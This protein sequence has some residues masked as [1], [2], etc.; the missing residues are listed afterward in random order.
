MRALSRLKVLVLLNQVA[1]AER[2]R[3]DAE[4]EH[5]EDAGLGA[6]EVAGE[7]D[8]TLAEVAAG[9]FIGV[10]VENAALGATG[11]DQNGKAGVEGALDGR[12]GL[13]G[14]VAASGAFN[15]EAASAE[16]AGGIDEAAIG[17][18]VHLVQVHAIFKAA[19]V[20]GLAEAE[21]AGKEDAVFVDDAE[22]AEDGGLEGFNGLGV[23]LGGVGSGVDGFVEED[24]DALIA[25]G[26][27]DGNAEG[28]ADVGR[29][30]IRE[31]RGVTHGTDDDDW[32]G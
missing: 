25:G 23:G 3:G 13:R 26:R 21:G 18:G 11:R 32:L 24:K 12:Q 14:N 10:G 27:V 9:A 29:T 8:A 20:D 4:G 17:A 31:L 22:G 16:F 1:K 5:E 2:I 6:G 15:D 19:G 7:D 30:V 28:G